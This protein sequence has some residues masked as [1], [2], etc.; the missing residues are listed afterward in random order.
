VVSPVHLE[1]QTP[2]VVIKHK[3]PRR[4]SRN[5]ENVVK[6]PFPAKTLIIGPGN[7][8]LWHTVTS[9]IRRPGLWGICYR[10]EIGT[11]CQT[12]VFRWLDVRQR[13]CK[14][15]ARWRGRQRQFLQRKE[16]LFNRSDCIRRRHVRQVGTLDDH[17][18]PETEWK[19]QSQNMSCRGK[20]RGGSND[21]AAESYGSW[22]CI[23]NTF[24]N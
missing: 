4:S 6:L 14:V 22:S 12:C 5:L 15:V 21:Q 13:T 20:D 17:M 19:G 10:T 9:P 1:K 24:P 18:N 23:N 16:R 3:R 2:M 7:Q 11:G 8:V